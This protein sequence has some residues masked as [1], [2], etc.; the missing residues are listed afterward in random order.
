VQLDE[1][2]ELVSVVVS[3]ARRLDGPRS[4]DFA[5]QLSSRINE[6]IP[7][8]RRVA[9]PASVA[10][11]VLDAARWH[12]DQDPL[13]EMFAEL[14][15]KACDREQRHTANPAFAEIVRQ[16]SPDEARLLYWIETRP[17]TLH[18]ARWF[19]TTSHMQ[20]NLPEHGT[21]ITSYEFPYWRL[22]NPEALTNGAYVGHL[23]H[24]GLI[25]FNQLS[26]QRSGRRSI[27]EL[28]LAFTAYGAL[29]VDAC[30]PADG[31]AAFRNDDENLDHWRT[32]PG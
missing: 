18:E 26:Q 15:T 30:I 29:F 3:M 14:L 1:D 27:R 23:T 22:G 6:R 12:E 4:N 32:L 5:L 11:R 20:M 9:P 21:E 10:G 17:V 13:F 2:G 7:K 28:Q 25:G 24:L 19:K 8:E 16:L 31:F